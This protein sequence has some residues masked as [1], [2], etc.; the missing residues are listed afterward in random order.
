MGKTNKDSS[1]EMSPIDFGN[2]K[3]LSQGGESEQVDI[4]DEAVWGIMDEVIAFGFSEAQAEKKVND[5]MDKLVADEVIPD[6][7]ELDD[8]DGEKAAWIARAVPS[9]KYQLRLQGDIM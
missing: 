8:H 2:M 4:V 3:D 7:P 6:V 1:I 9:I 5:T